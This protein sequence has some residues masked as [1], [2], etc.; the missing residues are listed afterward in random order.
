MKP[1]TVALVAA[2]GATITMFVFAYVR[3]RQ[4]NALRMIHGVGRRIFPN[5]LKENSNEK[6]ISTKESRLLLVTDLDCTLTMDNSTF[7]K[8][9][10]EVSKSADESLAT[11]NR[12]WLELEKK[13]KESG[14]YWLCYS[15]G[16]NLSLY[17]SLIA[18]QRKRVIESGVPD[19]AMML[20]DV[21]VTSDGTA[22]YWLERDNPARIPRLVFDKRWEA[23]L[24]QRWDVEKVREVFRN[25]PMVKKYGDNSKFWLYDRIEPLRVSC[26]IVGLENVEK[27]VASIRDGIHS[28]PPAEWD[29]RKELNVNV[30]YCTHTG[31]D[32]KGGEPHFWLVAIPHNG[33]KGGALRYIQSRLKPK[34]VLA[35]GDSGNDSPMFTIDGVHG[36]VVGN[37]K[38]ELRDFVEKQD[39]STRHVFAKSKFAGAIS[40]AM[41]VLKIL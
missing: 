37:A 6:F 31:A 35:A 3:R 24:Q 12:N 40:E 39:N 26:I 38:A 16:R 4:R 30:F 8:F 41:Q 36:V 11:F 17:E 29:G 14:E 7:K 1:Q 20:P 5:F 32:V 25:D 33:G 34:R 18:Q 2:T 22:I 13:S 10:D 23:R 15:T 27:A 19:A 21:L 28:L 9:P